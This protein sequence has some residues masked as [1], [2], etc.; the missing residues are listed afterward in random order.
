MDIVENYTHSYHEPVF[1]PLVPKHILMQ[2]GM[3][4]V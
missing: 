4:A 1:D 2:L 3:L